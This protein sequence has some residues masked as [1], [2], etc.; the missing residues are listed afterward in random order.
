MRR[1]L[2]DL[3]FAL[4]LVTMRVSLL[5]EK[6]LLLHHK[7]VICCPPKNIRGADEGADLGG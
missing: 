7:H 2:V 3:L 1:L 4:M 6:R 5:Q